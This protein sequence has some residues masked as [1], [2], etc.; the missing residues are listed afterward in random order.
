MV[1]AGKMLNRI[2]GLLERLKL[3]LDSKLPEEQ[4]GFRQRN[5]EVARL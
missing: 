1:R 4:T 2:I 5:L 3:A